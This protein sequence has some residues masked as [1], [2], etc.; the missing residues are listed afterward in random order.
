V[1]TFRTLRKTIPLNRKK[2][3]PDKFVFTGVYPV[4][5]IN[6]QLLQYN[7]DECLEKRDIPPEGVDGFEDKGYIHWLNIYGIDNADTIASICKRQGIHDL[8]IQDI[9]DVNQ[10]PKFQE[11]ENYSFLTLKSIAPSDND[12]VT[13][14]ISFVF[15]SNFLISFQEKEASFFEHVRHMLRDG[16]GII[17]ERGADYLLYALLESILD[18]YFKTLN[19]LDNEIEKYNFS[20]I[21][22][23]LSPHLLAN[24]ESNKKFAQYIK[25][26]IF[27]IKEFSLIAERGEYQWIDRRSIKYFL[28]IK[29]LCLTLMDGCD[30]LLWSLD[31]STNLF[32]YIQGH[33]MNQ[34]MKTLTVVATIFIPLTF[35]AGIYGMNFRNMPELS[36]Q[37]GYL[38]TWV[39][40]AFIVLGMLFYFR[41]KKWF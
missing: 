14:Q 39:A 33:R 12:I 8:V 13:E 19:R 4:S 25:K 38:T 3:D 37:Y 40:F 10:R 2:S 27:P 22:E 20:D 35:I 11:F 26:S 32:F 15:G 24:I 41:K 30:M 34:V 18:N 29:D 17:R 5:T 1:I 31:S 9:L 6:I 7:K 28:E 16:K 23:D 21:N 36:W